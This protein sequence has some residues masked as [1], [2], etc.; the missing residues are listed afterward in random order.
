AAADGAVAHGRPAV[1]IVA[2]TGAAERVVPHFALVAGE[3]GLERR[4]GERH[5]TAALNRADGWVAAG[6]GARK[7]NCWKKIGGLKTNKGGG[8]GA[9]RR[10]DLILQVSGKL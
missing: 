7:K 8:A 9:G 4:G 6:T 5:G 10:D 2:G 1:L 3:E